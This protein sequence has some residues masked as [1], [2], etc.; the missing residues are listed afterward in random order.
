MLRCYLTNLFFFQGVGGD[1]ISKTQSPSLCDC[2]LI[3]TSRKGIGGRGSLLWLNCSISAPQH[4]GPQ[5]NTNKR[6]FFLSICHQM[7]V[8]QMMDN[9]VYQRITMQWI[10]I[11]EADCVIQWIKIYPDASIFHHSNNW[12]QKFMIHVFRSFFLSH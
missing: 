12:G 11:R 1:N 5:F 7:L 2:W 3:Q 9:Y 4:C 8:V 10:S 6:A